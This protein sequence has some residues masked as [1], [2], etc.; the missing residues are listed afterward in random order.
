GVADLTIDC[1]GV[2]LRGPGRQAGKQLADK[3]QRGDI[4]EAFQAQVIGK[5]LLGS[6][7]CQAFAQQCLAHLQRPPELLAFTAG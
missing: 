3:M 5:G 1:Q 7:G 2:G 6:S 4:I